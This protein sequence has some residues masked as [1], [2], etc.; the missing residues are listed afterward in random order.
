MLEA[1][2]WLEMDILLEAGEILHSS[3]IAHY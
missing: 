2:L 3:L 1:Q